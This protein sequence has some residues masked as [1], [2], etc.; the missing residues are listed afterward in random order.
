MHDK[1]KKSD[2]NEWMN[3]RGT[4]ITIRNRLQGYIEKIIEEY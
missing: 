4:A 2:K 1:K 3:D